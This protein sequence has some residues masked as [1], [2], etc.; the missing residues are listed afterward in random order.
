M[1]KF[2]EEL[3]IDERLFKVLTTTF[4][5]SV[6]KKVKYGTSIFP[7]KNKVHILHSSINDFLYMVK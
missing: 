2:P 7:E 1:D 5:E 6:E 4:I 3:Q